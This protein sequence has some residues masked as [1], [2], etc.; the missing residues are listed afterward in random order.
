MKITDIRTRV[1]NVP[2]N[3]ARTEVLHLLV[4]VDTDEGIQGLGYT[5]DRSIAPV[6]ALVEEL[7]ESLRG[8]DPF[9]TEEALRRLRVPTGGTASAGAFALAMAAV[10][11][12]LWDIKGKATGQPLYRLLGGYGNRVPVYGTGAQG[13]GFSVE[14]LAEAAQ[15]EVERGFR[16]VKLRLGLERHLRDEEARIKAVREAVG[17]DVDIMVD[18]NQDWTT[19]QAIRSGR[20]LEEY[21]VYWLEDP[22]H[23]QDLRGLVQI[24]EALDMPVCAGEYYWGKEPFVVLL[25]MG[26]ADIVMIDLRRVGGITE[27]MK[28]AG[29]VEAHKRLVEGHQMPEV[30]QHLIAAIPNGHYVGYMT[31]STKLFQEPLRLE[32]GCLVVPE[33]PG[34]GLELDLEAVERWEVR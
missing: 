16:A 15:R 11:I 32:D 10:D 20:M 30:H 3:V 33:R 14:Q 8:L 27:W 31:T 2:T 19:Y 34:L 23:H 29:M 25:Q 7:S 12:A 5:Y 6:K 21:G 22:I 9:R 17:D 26:A 28:V 4:Q 13:R 1:V 18:I 24:A